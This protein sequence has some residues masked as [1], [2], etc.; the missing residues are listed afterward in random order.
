M[1][2]CGIPLFWVF[3]RTD[4]PN[5]CKT[6]FQ[7]ICSCLGVET[8]LIKSLPLL[9]IYH[10]FIYPN[11]NCVIIPE[12]QNYSLC[13][14]N[15]WNI[16]ILLHCCCQTVSIPSTKHLRN[17]KAAS[18]PTTDNPQNLIKYWTEIQKENQVRKKQWRTQR[19]KWLKT[20]LQQ[21]KTP[22]ASRKLFSSH[23]KN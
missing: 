19:K 4:Q 17:T 20:K 7:C 3:L 9:H 18:F 21:I 1:K 14:I 15:I 12:L 10:S 11:E 8:D 6:W 22:F 5:V 13:N 2:G 16:W 23:V